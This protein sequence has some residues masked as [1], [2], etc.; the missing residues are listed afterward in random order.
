MATVK[1]NTD[2]FVR[3]E[4]ARMFDSAVLKPNGGVLNSWS[5]SRV[6]VPI[7]QQK[8]IRMNRDTL[9]SNA[10]VDISA[11]AIVSLP[12]ASGRYMSL[13]ILNEDHHVNAVYHE[14]GTYELTM[15]QFDTRFVV[16]IL[17]TFVDPTDPDDIAVV[18]A[19]QD[20]VAV[21][22]TATGPYEHPDYDE[23]SRKQT[24]DALVSLAKGLPDAERMFGMKS[25]VDPVRHLIGT[26]FGWGGLP[27]SEAYYMTRFEP[28]PVG[29]YAL[30]LRDV[31]VDGFWSMTI[32]DRDGFLEANAYDAY[33]LN[34]VTAVADEDGSITLNFGPD[35]DG[36]SNYLYVMDGWNFVFRLYQ[37]RPSVLDGTWS[38]PEIS[39]LG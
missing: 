2:N 19:L 34:G 30:T 39:Q 37:P 21:E 26:A 12:Q 38:L 8:V 18:K 28:R 27:T 16:P 10:L 25:H 14:P 1:V 22:A 5:H 4:T 13:A 33:S 35:G 15:E 36:L 31:P 29:R 23:A 20:E 17:R 24:F 9:Y 11:G 3:A 32:Y 6:P 7:D